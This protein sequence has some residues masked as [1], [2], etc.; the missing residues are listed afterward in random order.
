M[1]EIT[2]TEDPALGRLTDAIQYAQLTERSLF[3]L[4]AEPVP[5]SRFLTLFGSDTPLVRT[6]EHPPFLRRAGFDL[7]AGETRIIRGDIRRATVP[8]WKVLELWRDGT[9][10]YGV[11]A[12]VQP[13]WGNRPPGGSLRVNPLALCEPVYLF[14]KLSAV[15]YGESTIRPQTVCY[16]VFFR[17]L[18]ENGKL[19]KL[20][21]GPLHPTFFESGRSHV[22]P[23]SDMERTVI[24]E[25][26]EIDPGAVAYQ[27]LQEVYH[28]FGISDEGIP[29]TKK[30]ADGATVVDPEELIKAGT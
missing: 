16:R 9:L 23:D 28:W 24:W 13:C 6:L 29:Y 4:I 18:A 21:E 11:D 22:A 14:A 25:Q 17:R 15:I 10:I 30:S 3:A 8:T 2:A 5:S 12:Y 20:S 1:N 7:E 27:V 26:P 19:A